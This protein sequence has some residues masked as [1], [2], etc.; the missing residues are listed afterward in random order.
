MERLKSI[1]RKFIVLHDIDVRKAWLVDGLS[2]LL[3]LIKAN[4]SYDSNEGDYEAATLSTQDALQLK[5]GCTG[6]KM[7]F[8]T[9][10]D[11][12]NM[13]IHLHKKA[14]IM[15]EDG[16]G[17]EDSNF[18]CLVDAVKYI[19][20]ILEQIVDHQADERV[21]SSVGYRIRLSPWRQ[22]EGF[23]F[24]D[25]ATKSDPIWPR[26]MELRDDGEGWVGLT[27]AIHA[28]TLFGKGFG[29]LLEPV[30]PIR[31]LN[32]CEMC[33][34]N[35][36]APAQR[37]VLAVSVPELERIIEQTGDKDVT[38][39]SWKLVNELYLTINPGL[40][41]G[42]SGNNRRGCHQRIQSIQRN[43][44]Y[45]H[46]ENSKEQKNQ[47]LLWRVMSKLTHRHNNTSSYPEKGDS[48]L[49][50]FSGGGIL[51]GLPPKRL[52]KKHEESHRIRKYFSKSGGIFNPTSANPELR[53]E[54]V[55]SQLPSSLT[56]TPATSRTIKPHD[57]ST[58][59]TEPSAY[60]RGESNVSTVDM[61]HFSR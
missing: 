24:M 7:A 11:S 46:D 20:H 26:A 58:N 52:P 2:A 28:T 33:S 17:K 9:L 35:S 5:G 45:S 61:R 51:L 40:F 31:D 3:H 32:H 34:W 6:R 42:C 43:T 37:D 16:K 23:D 38:G 57:E 18:Y 8:E 53:D 54:Q 12:R 27:R 15:Q 21:E 13:K 19:M 10:S 41:S 29:E 44:Q 4:M 60:T 36:Q 25:I 22:L 50:D 55:V 59:L 56:T 30:R 47:K 48:T 1:G 14:D 39:T 49:V